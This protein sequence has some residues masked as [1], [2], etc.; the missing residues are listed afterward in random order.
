[1]LRVRSP[2][3]DVNGCKIVN[4]Y[5][6][7]RTRLQTLDFPVFP[8]PCLY[9][10]DFNCFHTDWGYDDNRPDGECLADWASINCLALLY[11]AKDTASFYSGRWNTGINPDLAFA[12]V[13]PNVAYRIEVSLRSSSGHKQVDLW[14][15]HHQGLLWQCQTYLLSD[16]TSARPN[17]VTTL[18]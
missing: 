9:A 12:S 14:L 3:V 5:K 2:G 10:G 4:V 1:M 6:L 17:G 13:V 16:G 7:L 15:L 8:H 18:L 11:N